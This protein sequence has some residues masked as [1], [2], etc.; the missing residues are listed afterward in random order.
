MKFNAIYYVLLINF[1]NSK[2]YFKKKNAESVLCNANNFIYLNEKPNKIHTENGREFVNKLLEDYC[3]LT[4]I[5]NT[6]IHERPYHPNYR[7]V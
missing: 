1:L 6:L 7:D 3:K 5:I 2:L 4:N